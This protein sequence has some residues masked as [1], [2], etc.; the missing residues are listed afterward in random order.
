MSQQ[1][2]N[3]A[4]P[5]TH[6][7]KHYDRNRL[8]PGMSYPVGATEIEQA[9]RDADATL[10]HMRMLLPQGDG[11]FRGG[12]ILLWA[13]WS[14]DYPGSGPARAANLPRA[15]LDVRAVPSELRQTARHLIVDSGL[16]RAAK[17]FRSAAD[18]GNSWRASRHT[19]TLWLYPDGP[20]WQED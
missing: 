1:A 20:R 8:R 9:F 14:G 15:S 12:L 13:D 17:W 3:E 18:S 16:E 19:L 6:P 2:N 4:E 10:D 7:W 5:Q 11:V